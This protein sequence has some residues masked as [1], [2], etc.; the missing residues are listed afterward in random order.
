MANQLPA[1]FEERRFTRDELNRMIEAGLFASDARRIELIHGRLVVVPPE[2]PLHA[3][4]STGLRDRLIAAYAGRAH[5]RDAKPLDCGR[6]EQPEPDLAVVLGTARDYNTRHPRGTETLLVV[7]ISRRTTQARD[8]EKAEIYASALVPV[9]WLIDLP[10]RRVELHSEPQNNRY[11][12]V[13]LLGEDEEL[14][15]PGIGA[16]LRVGELMG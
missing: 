3:S 1:V 10:Q 7:E 8:R 5:V 16:T 6:E 9:Y 13:R 14:V 4:A 15:L 2:G 11:T 12:F